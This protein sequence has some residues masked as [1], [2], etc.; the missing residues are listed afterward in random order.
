MTGCTGKG[1]EGRFV[2]RQGWGGVATPDAQVVGRPVG[3]RAT[4]GQSKP[5]QRWWAGR[6]PAWPIQHARLLRPA[7]PAER[8]PSCRPTLQ[9]L[10]R[11]LLRACRPGYTLPGWQHT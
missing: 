10:L 9:P 4:A 5:C 2:L 6:S 11:L 8:P 3:A 1:G 7:M